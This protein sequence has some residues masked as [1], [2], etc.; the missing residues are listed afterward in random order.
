LGFELIECGHYKHDVR[1]ALAPAIGDHGI[2]A[3]SLSRRLERL[4][5]HIEALAEEALSGRLAAL[6]IVREAADIATAEAALARLSAGARTIVFF[7]T[8]GSSLGGQ[9]LA[10]L[11]GWDVPG[12]GDSAQRLRP[13]TRFYDNLD[14]STLASAMAILDPVTSRFVLVS[15]SGNTPETLAQ[16]IVALQHIRAA[17]LIERAGEMMLGLTEPDPS[18]RTNGLRRLLAAHGVPVLDHHTGIGGRYSVLSNVGLLPALARGLDVRSLRAGA[19]SVVDALIADRRNP[20]ALA[21]AVGAAL[22]VA[23]SEERGVHIQV[24]MPYADRLQAFARWFVQLWAES[25]GKAGRGTTPIACLGPL[26]QHSQLQLFMDG[27]R[28]HLATIIRLP[29]AGT[30]SRLDADLCRVAGLDVMAGRAVGDLV[31]AQAVGVPAA[32]TAAGRPLRAID[33]ARLDAGTM[34]ALLMHFMIETILAGRLL[35]V[36]PFD[37]PAVELGKR[38]TRDELVKQAT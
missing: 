23:L 11:A 21:P 4:G 5:A 32:L 28:H 33:L 6:A 37:Q 34:G 36:D 10:Q 26:D 15:K 14:A 13:R 30:G 17:G 2:D 22:A 25:L 16:A 24:M 3:A 35:D 27:P 12:G 29:T 31:A 9:T 20:A 8:G 19:A 7:G 1:Q 38:L 18:G